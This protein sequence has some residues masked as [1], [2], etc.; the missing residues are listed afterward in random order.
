VQK[1]EVNGSLI[2]PVLNMYNPIHVLML[3]LRSNVPM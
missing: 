2:K 1:E 3:K